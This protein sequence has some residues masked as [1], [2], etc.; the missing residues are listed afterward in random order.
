MFDQYDPNKDGVL[1]RFEVQQMIRDL[2]SKRRQS[3]DAEKLDSYV[4]T[5]MREADTSRNGKI[6]KE[7]FY[8]FYKAQ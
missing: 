3:L 5:Y 7:E 6:D 1:E 8:R 2:A 4:E